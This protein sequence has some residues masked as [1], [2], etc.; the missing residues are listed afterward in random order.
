[1]Q[2]LV[3]HVSFDLSFPD[4][5]LLYYELVEWSSFFVDIVFVTYYGKI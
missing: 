2:N 3:E 4:P 1:M 5:D